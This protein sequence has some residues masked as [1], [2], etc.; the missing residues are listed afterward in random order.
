MHKEQIT[1]TNQIKKWAK[2]LNRHFSKESI[3][4]ASRH[5]K[6][7]QMEFLS[8]LSGWQIQ[9]ASMKMRIQ[10]LAS[11]SGLG[12]QSCGELYVAM[13]CGVGHWRSLDPGFLFLWFR[14]AATAP[15][16]LL[17]W[18]LPYAMGEAL[19]RKIKRFSVLKQNKDMRKFNSCL[20]KCFMDSLYVL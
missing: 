16:Q 7:A 18:E 13:S 10:S 8:W 19:K 4:M 17:A 6:N 20:H 9:L 1:K 2:D 15:I 5:M 12:I 14:Q 11:L 3:H